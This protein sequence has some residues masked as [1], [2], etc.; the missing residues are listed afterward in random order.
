MK[1]SLILLFFLGAAYGV[2]AQRDQSAILEPVRQLFDAMEKG[3]SS[4]LRKAFHSDAR[5][6]SIVLD[7]NGGATWKPGGSVSAFGKSIAGAGPGVLAEP[8]YR[9]R[10]HQYGSYAEVVANYAFYLR[11]SFHHCG[12]DSFQLML[13]EDGWK[14]V[15]LTDT[16][17][18][19]GCRVPGRIKR[20]MAH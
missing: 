8:I 14:I 20:R 1:K 10:A 9:I 18:T 7:E 2:V 3:D 12:I 4:L 5:M 6:Q 16:R 19:H 13:T 11:G 17:Q 15:N